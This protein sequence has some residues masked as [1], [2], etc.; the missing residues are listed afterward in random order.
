MDGEIVD[1]LFGLFDQRV[2]EDVPGQVFGDAVHLFQRL[3][4]RHRADRNRAVADDP[5]ARVVDVAAGGEVHHIVGAP[6]GRPHHLVDFFL[7]RGGDGRVADIGVDLH[8]EVAADDLRFQFGMVDVGRNDGAAGGDLVAHE[9]RRDEFRDVRAE[10]F[11]L[12]DAL[13]G[14][15]DGGA[16]AKVFARGDVDHLLGDD[17]GLGEFI[18]GDRAGARAAQGAVL[19]REFAGEVFAG[20]AAIVFR[21][22]V[23]AVIFLDMA[24]LQHPV[25]PRAGEAFLHVDGHRRVRVRTGRVIDRHRRLIGGRVQVDLAVRHGEIW[26][27]MGVDL[28]AGG[29]RPGGDLRGGEFGLVGRLVHCAGFLW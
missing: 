25:T 20:C 5:F 16:A 27:G 22:H 19:H 24:A 12:F 13:G 23:A 18:L 14:A 4:D 3:I 21:L 28:A 29:Q 7:D 10:A 6:A 17:A 15:F 8:K 2:A 11:A 26:Q 9:F 1:A